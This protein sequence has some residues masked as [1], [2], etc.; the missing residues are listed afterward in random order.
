ADT[1]YASCLTAAPPNGCTFTAAVL[2][3]NAAITGTFTVASTPVTLSSATGASQNST[4]TVTPAGGF[5]GTVAVTATAASL[6]AGVTCIPSPLNIN[7]TAATAV[8]GTLGCSVT[9][10]STV[11]SASNALQ[12]R[13]LE[14]KTA[15]SIGGKGWWT[16]SAG[17]GFAALFLLFLPGG[18]K[19]L[20]AALGLGLVCVLSFTLGCSGNYGGGGG[21]TKMATVTKLTV[22][23]AKVISPAT[24]TFSVA[25]TGGTPAGQVALFD[26][27]TM[28]GT[29]VTVTG[30]TATPTAPALSVGTHTISAHYLGDTYTNA[31]ASGSLNL[32]VTGTTTIAI[33]T[34]PV[35]TPVA[36]AITV[37]I[38]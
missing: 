2:T 1:N 37:T 25:V 16:L 18:R 35:A 14:A 6:P 26:G 10:T 38:N 19:K 22:T 23:S 8:T 32:T 30:G 5:T 9:A 33:T 11:L 27:G 12:D 4:I 24:F 31:S 13:V 7:V 29:A 3:V 28:I 20:R 17:T 34:S 36:P 15:P 21:V